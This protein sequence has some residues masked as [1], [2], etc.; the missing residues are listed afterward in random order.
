MRKPRLI[1]DKTVKLPRFSIQDRDGSF[2]VDGLETLAMLGQ[3]TPETVL[4]REGSDEAAPVARWHFA[5]RVFP[6]KKILTLA[7]PTMALVPVRQELGPVNGV[8]SGKPGT[9]ITSI[10][11]LKA[12]VRRDPNDPRALVILTDLKD[13][14]HREGLTVQQVFAGY[15]N[16]N[17]TLNRRLTTKAVYKYIGDATRSNRSAALVGCIGVDFVL[18]YMALT[19]AGYERSSYVYGALVI[20]AILGF[21]GTFAFQIER[22]LNVNPVK[23]AIGIMFTSY[24]SFLTA[25]TFIMYHAGLADAHLTFWQN[26]IS[27]VMG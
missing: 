18:G 9:H 20:S 5:D 16:S 8:G 3:I 23:V 2:T 14:M 6:A 17:E 13:K 10:D 24:A 15:F 11:E 4:T 27:L 7:A 21:L 12:I 19:S 26:L 25:M 1:A 22:W